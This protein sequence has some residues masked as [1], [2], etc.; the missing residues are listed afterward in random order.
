MPRK[1]KER[2]QEGRVPRPIPP[3]YQVSQRYDVKRE[4]LL[5]IPSISETEPFHGNTKKSVWCCSWC[6]LLYSCM[7]SLKHNR[8][9]PISASSGFRFLPPSVAAHSLWELVCAGKLLGSRA[10]SETMW[11][12]QFLELF[13]CFLMQLNVTMLYPSKH[14][15]STR[16]IVLCLLLKITD[17]IVAQDEIQRPIWSLH[18]VPRFLHSVCLRMKKATRRPGATYV[19]PITNSAVQNAGWTGAKTGWKHICSLVIPP[20][21]P[22]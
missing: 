15:C 13:P 3:P 9:L 21:L 18:L 17:W 14:G 11:Q 20:G 2:H 10:A 8:N 12:G 7:R 6:T 22:L 19:K 5:L 4:M 16:E 1:G